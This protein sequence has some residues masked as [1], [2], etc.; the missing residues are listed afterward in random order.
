MKNYGKSYPLL[1]IIVTFCTFIL[2]LFVSLVP[3]AMN[4]SFYEDQFI[5]NNT[6][7]VAKLTLDDL[8]ELIDHTLKYTYGNLEHLQY[9]ITTTDGVTK[10]AFNERE[11]AHME[12][13]QKLFINGRRLT[14]ICALLFVIITFFLVWKK[15][16][17]NHKTFT[18]S[19]ITLSS[20][21]LIMLAVLIYAA[22]NFDQAF[23]IFHQIFF[24]NDLWLLD[25]NDML[26]IMLPESLFYAIATRTL[27]KFLIFIGIISGLLLFLRHH[28]IKK[29]KKLVS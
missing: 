29:E 12:D 17:I 22:T 18:I 6:T 16:K 21:F 25:F 23:T 10:D 24:N 2:V 13:V 7:Q 15:D 11:I 1:S 20:I 4:R 14:D 19:L 9:Q 3:T 8:N 5:E 26:I 27:I 28:Y